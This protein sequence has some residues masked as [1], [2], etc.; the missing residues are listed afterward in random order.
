MSAMRWRPRPADPG[1]PLRRGRRGRRPLAPGAASPAG[2]PAP[3]PRVHTAQLRGRMPEGARR[4]LAQKRPDAHARPT[5]TG[6]GV[7]FVLLLFVLA[8]VAVFVLAWQG[9]L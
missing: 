9:Q 4:H 3:A 6:A 1:R 5:G 8:V 7:N 2:S